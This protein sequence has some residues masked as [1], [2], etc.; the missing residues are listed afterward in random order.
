MTTPIIPQDLLSSPQIIQRVWKTLAPKIVI[1][2]TPIAIHG[3][4]EVVQRIIN[5]AVQKLPYDNNLPNLNEIQNLPPLQV[6]FNDVATTVI[7][8]YDPVTGKNVCI[9]IAGVAMVI[10]QAF[11]TW[12]LAANPGIQL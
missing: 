4:N 9:S 8:V 2:N 6:N 7:T 10:Q 3:N 11:V 1:T 12:Y 5:F